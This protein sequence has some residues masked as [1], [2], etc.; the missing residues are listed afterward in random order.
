MAEERRPGGRTAG[1]RTVGERLA[2]LEDNMEK[3]EAKIERDGEHVW[4]AIT[5]M[6]ACITEGNRDLR[7]HLDSKFAAL[8]GLIIKGGG[9]VAAVMAGI[10]GYLFVRAL[11]W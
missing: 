8:Y 11:G 10:I 4:N 9:A 5:K 3:V 2:V 7:H 6:R 1:G